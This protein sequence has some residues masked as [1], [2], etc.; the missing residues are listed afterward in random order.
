MSDSICKRCGAAIRQFAKRDGDPIWKHIHLDVFNGAISYYRTCRN[1]V[2]E[3]ITE[4]ESEGA[5]VAPTPQ[6]ATTS[7]RFADFDEA[8]H[9]FCKW[10]KAHGQY[11]L[12]GGARRESIWAARGWIAREQL[13][14]GVE[15]TGDSLHEDASPSLTETPQPKGEK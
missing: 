13:A 11:M 5:V 8:D 12:S 2:A 15:V 3:P 14:D 1:A 6:T 4:D 9:P 10:W 7:T